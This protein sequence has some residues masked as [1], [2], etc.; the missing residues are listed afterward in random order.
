MKP[1][2]YMEHTADAEFF[3]YGKTLEEAFTNAVYAS[4]NIVCDHLKVSP[5]IK[6]NVTIS[7]AD[8][9]ALLYSFIEEFIFLLDAEDFLLSK[10]DEIKIEEKDSKWHFNA[11]VSGDVAQNYET[12]KAIKA[13]TY[14]NMEI[15]KEGDTWK[16]HVVI[17]I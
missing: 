4:M 14:N 8:N 7:A 16:L 15:S 3:A 10:I 2:E 12:E 17:D 11:N 9:Q 13:A 5:K 1:F 6:K